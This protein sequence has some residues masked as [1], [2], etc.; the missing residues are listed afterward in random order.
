MS[1]FNWR[2]SFSAPGAFAVVDTRRGRRHVATC[3]T[4]ESA[5]ELS[6]K[7]EGLRP[8]WRAVT[9]KTGLVTII[10]QA[11]TPGGQIAEA[12][13]S[14]GRHEGPIYHRDYLGV[15]ITLVE[16]RLYAVIAAEQASRR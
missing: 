1:R 9:S 4:E 3:L 5:E 7:L 12:A 13:W 8:E 10:A 15:V 6:T 11:N 16:D 14:L 2:K